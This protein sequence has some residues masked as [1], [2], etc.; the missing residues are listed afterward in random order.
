MSSSSFCHLIKS[1]LQT[2]EAYISKTF[3]LNDIKYGRVVKYDTLYNIQKS[4]PVALNLHNTVSD[5]V[6]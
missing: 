1:N 3:D 2:S 6:I 5:D 4:G